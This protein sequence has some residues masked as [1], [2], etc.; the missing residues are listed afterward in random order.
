MRVGAGRTASVPV[1]L[2]AVASVT[3]VAVDAAVAVAVVVGTRAS[4]SADTHWRRP[5]RTSRAL[6]V[7]APIAPVAPIA[8][9]ASSGIPI[10]PTSATSSVTS[11]TA[12]VVLA[13]GFHLASILALSWLAGVGEAGRQGL[14]RKRMGRRRR[15]DSVADLCG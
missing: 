14:G 13:V 7:D 6:D 2:A 4:G 10:P 1:T 5:M 12:A 8:R 3:D 11:K 15:D 9:V